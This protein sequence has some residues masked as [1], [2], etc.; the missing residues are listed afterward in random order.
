MV[1]EESIKVWKE[2]AESTATQATEK[3]LPACLELGVFKISRDLLHWFE[4][5]VGVSSAELRH[6][7][8]GVHNLNGGVETVHSLGLVVDVVDVITLAMTCGAPWSAMRALAEAA[9]HAFLPP[10]PGQNPRHSL[11]SSVIS[12]PLLES[13]PPVTR[14]RLVNL[15]WELHLSNQGS[16]SSQS[17]IMVK[18]NEFQARPVTACEGSGPNSN[19][20]SL[21]GDLLQHARDVSKKALTDGNPAL[22][23]QVMKCITGVD[24]L[25]KL[26]QLGQ[27]EAAAAKASAGDQEKDEKE[28]I[29]MGLY[30]VSVKEV[31]L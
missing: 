1:S 27:E 6:F 7:L 13:I 4:L 25:A 15:F 12:V 30:T 5:Q 19:H 17:W 3:A 22:V 20:L 14:G 29:G 18:R 23:P 21:T 16:A 28:Q 2:T 26:I 24:S 31:H 10:A 8:E 9:L 11:L